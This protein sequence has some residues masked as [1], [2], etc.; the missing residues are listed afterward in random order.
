M[1]TALAASTPAP[2][3]ADVE[4]ELAYWR[5]VHADGH[6]G[7]RDFS[8]YSTVLKLGY[9]VYLAY[10]RATEAQRYRVL[11][12][13]YHLLRPSLHIPWDEA[14]WLVRHAWRHL[15]DAARPH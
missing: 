9:D 10:P 2:V 11:Q 4:A 14:R 6:L 15:Q 13:G 5:G 12:D 8:D 7:D 3:A 1:P